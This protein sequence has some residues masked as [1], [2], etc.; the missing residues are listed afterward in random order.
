VTDQVSHPYK[1][2]G[3]FTFVDMR[4]EHERYKNKMVS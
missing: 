3:A 2:R 4:R 1:I